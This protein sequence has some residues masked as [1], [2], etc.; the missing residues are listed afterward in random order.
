MGAEIIHS[1]MNIVVPVAICSIAIAPCWATVRVLDLAVV[2]LQRQ[3]N[4]LKHELEE[5]KNVKNNG[6]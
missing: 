2:D 6:N 3:L 4:D 5:M 1:I